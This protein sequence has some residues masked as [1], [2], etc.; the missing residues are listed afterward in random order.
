[1]HVYV[2]VCAH[3]PVSIFPLSVDMEQSLLDE[4]KSNT[5]QVCSFPPPHPTLFLFTHLCSLFSV[6]VSALPL[7]LL[8][9]APLQHLGKGSHYQQNNYIVYMQ[10][11]VKCTD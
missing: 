3:I 10:R 4:I 9:N 2:C 1:M 11:A 5:N 6:L 7:L 8:A